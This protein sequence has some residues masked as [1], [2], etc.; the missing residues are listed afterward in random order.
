MG[1]WLQAAQMARRPIKGGQALGCFQYIEQIK[2]GRA[3]LQWFLEPAGAVK[4]PVGAIAGSAPC[5]GRSETRSE[6]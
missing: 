3:R 2:M 6:T 5:W 4:R 1:A